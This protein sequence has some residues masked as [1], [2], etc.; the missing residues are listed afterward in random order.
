MLAT[1]ARAPQMSH[2]GPG[3]R[4]VKTQM[5]R[6]KTTPSAR[7]CKSRSNE[8]VCVVFPGDLEG[9]FSRTQIYVSEAEN[10]LDTTG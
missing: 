8:V 10:D 6:G 1:T 4:V 3:G 5:V 7:P 9:G 2:K